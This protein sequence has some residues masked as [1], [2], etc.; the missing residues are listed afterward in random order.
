MDISLD[1]AKIR[2][3][4]VQ[5][6]LDSIPFAPQVDFLIKTTNDSIETREMTRGVRP[7]RSIKMRVGMLIDVPAALKAR[8]VAYVPGMYVVYDEEQTTPYTWWSYPG[9]TPGPEPDPAAMFITPYN[10]H[11]CC[12]PYLRANQFIQ[13]DELPSVSGP[14]VGGRNGGCG[15]SSVIMNSLALNL[16][17]T[18]RCPST[19]S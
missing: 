17:K 13:T 1:E 3:G 4:E 19:L 18:T 9:P 8:N 14:G 7:Y 5:M 6:I 12:F 16:P 10:L 15:V 11:E 2:R